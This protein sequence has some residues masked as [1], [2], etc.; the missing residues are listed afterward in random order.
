M[1][2]PDVTLGRAISGILQWR[3]PQL[4][5]LPRFS[6]GVASHSTPVLPSMDPRAPPKALQQHSR[7]FINDFARGRSDELC[8]LSSRVFFL[9]ASFFLFPLAVMFII[10]HTYSLLSSLVVPHFMCINSYDNHNCHYMF[11]TE[12]D[13]VQIAT[14]LDSDVTCPLGVASCFLYGHTVLN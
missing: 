5:E 6:R 7:P 1:S 14:A 10:C 12:I 3:M 11:A 4:W 2:Q 9:I 8:L 13:K